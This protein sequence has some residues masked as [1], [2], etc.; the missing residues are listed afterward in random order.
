M[1]KF[2]LI[3]LCAFC[4]DAFAQ[5]PNA[6]FENWTSNASYTVPVG[7][8][9]S[10]YGADS[11][12]DASSGSKALV[13]WTWYTYAI[14]YAYNGQSAGSF[15]FHKA[16]SP[17]TLKATSLTGMYKF[18]TAYV[19]SKDSAVV[20]VLLKKYNTSLQKVDTV[21]F[22][23]KKLP[24]SNNYIPFTVN[25]SDMM[26]GINPDSVVV[27]LSSQKRL[28]DFG[29]AQNTCDINHNDCAYFYI[30]DLALNT[31]SGVVDIMDLFSSSVF[32]NPSNDKITFN[33]SSSKNSATD[34]LS[35][36]DNVGRP[37][38]SNSISPGNVLQLDLFSRGSYYY[39]ITTDDAIPIAKGKFVV[40]K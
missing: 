3:I 21:G 5:L 16:G 27:V 32:P 22:A 25:I 36:Y 10:G 31:T 17:F 24:A 13:V 40:V 28:F 26:P 30:D 15:D 29:N 38:Y 14:G 18:D 35:I 7:W 8:S 1:N 34:K 6:S 20:M 11:T 39:I 33:Y 19:E 12:S 4:I 2:L 23:L 37:C 9:S